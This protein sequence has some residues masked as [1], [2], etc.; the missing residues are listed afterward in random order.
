MIEIYT[1][2]SCS[3]NSGKGGWGLVIVK[4][5]TV[6]QEESGVAF[7]TTNNRME[8]TA[9]LKA[10]QIMDENEGELYYTIYT[11]SAYIANCFK[12][13]WYQKWLA[14]GWKTSNRTAI[15]NQDLWKLIL[16]LHRESRHHITIVHVKGH[17]GN[18]FNER[19][20]TLATSWRGII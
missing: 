3:V 12:D 7:D 20:D 4:D 14:N 18:K 8:L 15:K 5:G 19:A 10:M 6:I 2:G 11:D 17:N 1:D 16:K 13:K 9:F